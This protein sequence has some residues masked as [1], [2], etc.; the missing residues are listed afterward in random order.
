[1]HL[2]LSKLQLNKKYLTAKHQLKERSEC[3]NSS[4]N[5]ERIQS[6]NKYFNP[7]FHS[8]CFINNLISRGTLF[9]WYLFFI[10]PTLFRPLCIFIDHAC[11]RVRCG[12]F[13]CKCATRMQLWAMLVDEFLGCG[14][15]DALLQ[16]RRTASHGNWTPYTSHY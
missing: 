8:W 16:N 9:I 10:H 13:L 14:Q 12:H 11:S 5:V 6:I 7:Y 3:V 1:M 15:S 4:R 2:S